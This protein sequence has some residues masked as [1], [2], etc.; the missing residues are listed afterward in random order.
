MPSF[1]HLLAHQR[2]LSLDFDHKSMLEARVDSTRKSACFGPGMRS[3]DA[4]MIATGPFGFSKKLLGHYRAA[5]RPLWPS[6]VLLFWVSLPTSTA[7]TSLLAVAFA[8]A[9]ALLPPLLPLYYWRSFHRCW[10]PRL[11]D[12]RCQLLLLPRLQFSPRQVGA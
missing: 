1:C 2:L 6:F 10:P 3:P 11:V 8:T 12:Y 4:C 7:Q 5:S 9:V